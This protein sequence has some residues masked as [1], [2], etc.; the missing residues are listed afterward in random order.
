LHFRA[1]KRDGS[2]TRLARSIEQVASP[3]FSADLTAWASCDDGLRLASG[4]RRSYSDVSTCSDARIIDM[5]RLD[6]FCG[7]DALTGLLTVDAGTNLDEILTHFVP[8]GFFLPVTPGTRFATLGGAVANDVH[9]K[10]HHRSGTIGCHVEAISLLRSDRGVIR[11]S[12][13]SDPEMFAATIG[14]LG[15]TGII[16]DVT[17]RLQPIRSAWLDCETIV[18]PDLDRL[19]AALSGTQ[20]NFEHGVAWIDCAARGKSL[21]RGIVSAAN[22]CEDG[23]LLPHDA[24]QRVQIPTDRLGGLLNPLSI[25]AFNA[26]YYAL[27]SRRPARSRVHYAPFFYPLDAIGGW[28]KL[29]GRAGFYQYQCV[30]PTSGAAAG[31]RTLIEQIS[32][33]G[34]GSFL[35]VLKSFGCKPSPGYLSFPRDGLTLAL[36]FRNRGPETLA[37]LDRLDETVLSSGGRLYPAKDA[38]LPAPLFATGYPSLET[39]RPHVDPLITS[40]FWK[41]IN[42]A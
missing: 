2:W 26:L 6:R 7:F 28:N 30:I 12:A 27:G 34:Q 20:R 16:L 35:A 8:R 17:I 31:V 3:R 37:L 15:L 4:A 22:W 38:R 23:D 25:R 36:D 19:I 40:D 21:G 13:H 32:A 10:N 5:T 42:C 14:G 11:L 39:F 9:G 41:R 33:S 18:C 29:Y 1:E 24:G